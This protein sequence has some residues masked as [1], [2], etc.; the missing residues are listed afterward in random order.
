MS[1]NRASQTS[2]G[3]FTTERNDTYPYIDSK[4]V[5]LK[6]KNV[7]ITGASKG[8]GK[9]TAI[10]FA[11]A[12]ASGIAL[13]ARSSLEPVV[14]EVLQA[15]K[16]AGHPEPRIS[17]V[18]LDVTNR[19]S[20]DAAAKKVSQDLD[21]RIDILINNAG[22]FAELKAIQDIDPDKWW[23]N[24]EVN[25]KGPFLVFRAFHPLLLKSSLKI[26]INVVSVG[27]IMTLP[28]SSAYGP[29]KLATLR[30]TEQINQDNGEGKE[31]ILAIAVHPGGVMTEM[32]KLLPE[33]LHVLLPDTPQL[34]GDTLAWLGA[35]RRE[36][37]GGRY[38]SA[39]WDMEELSGKKEEIVKR[40][41]LKMRLAV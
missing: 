23:R 13:G 14:Q 21:G 3:L 40:D 41:L 38:V 11:Q 16:N 9:A 17:T 34:S 5:N 6:G 10:S 33:E 12:G 37:L 4:K 31:G 29:S 28:L 22:Y 26:L 20:V 24:Y 27:A 1:G 36:W 25:V 7:F 2:D 35:E 8:L 32:G 15:A 19:E 39:N 18:S 30:I